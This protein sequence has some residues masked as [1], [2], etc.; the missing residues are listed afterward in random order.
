MLD[1]CRHFYPVEEIKRILEQCALLKLNRFHWHLSDDQ[2]FRLESKRFPQL[3][4]T[5]SFRILSPDDPL[6]ARGAA[7][8]G[9]AY[10]GYY[11]Q[12]EVRNIVAYAKARQIEIIPELEVPGHSSSILASFPQYTC[13]GEPLRVKNTFGVHERIFCAGNQ[14]GY[15]FLYELLKEIF[16]LFPFHYVHLGG[17]EAPK[18]IWHECPKCSSLLKREGLSGYEALQAYF[19][20]KLIDFCKAE[21]KV[22]VVWNESAAS[23]ELDE[24]AVVQYWAELAPGQSYMPPEFEKGRRVIF[25]CQNQ[26]Y[27][28]N[29]YAE[30]PLR[31]TLL[32]ETEV[33]GTPVPEEN[34]L[35]V[36]AAMW[37]EWTPESSDIEAMMYPRLLA[38]AECGWCR[39]KKTEE[40]LSRARRYLEIKELNILS[41]I[42]WE[43]ATVSGEK[44]LE[45]I[46]RSMLELGRKY[47][48]MSTGDSAEAAGKA[49]AVVPEGLQ[50]IDMAVMIRM[51]MEEKMRGAYTTEEIEKVIQMI[52]GGMG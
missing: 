16:D 10:G 1:V 3:N 2:E 28:S 44:A 17:D 18:R 31:A 37:T 34:V 13:S 9:T 19:T 22:P 39:Q 4:Q 51:Y 46:A 48:S 32:Y 40:F 24:A 14:E 49:E 38:L 29:S 11:T 26:F 43:E 8:A 30:M 42:A 21:G 45:M 6:V 36:E 15:Q 25:S 27:C 50:S 35:G 12:E 7:E 47:G 52:M 20:G 33:K 5:G 23:G 41:P